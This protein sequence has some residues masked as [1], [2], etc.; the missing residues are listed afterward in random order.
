MPHVTNFSHISCGLGSTTV[1]ASGRDFLSAFGPVIYAVKVKGGLVKIGYTSNVRNRVQSLG[2]GK[3]ALLAM[4]LNGTFEEERAIHARL[5]GHAVKGREWYSA[6]DP[7]VVA[8]VN[9][10]RA[11]MGLEPTERI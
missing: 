2:L 6:T 7:D 3:K 11:E 1:R 10:M 8:I 9:E 5:Q 4:L